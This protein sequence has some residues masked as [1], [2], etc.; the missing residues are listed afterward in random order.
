[1]LVNHFIFVFTTTYLLNICALISNVHLSLGTHPSKSNNVPMKIDKKNFELKQTKNKIRQEI[2]SY[3][4]N[5]WEI[6]ENPN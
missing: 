4:L 6:K 3:F 2:L 1:M 5:I